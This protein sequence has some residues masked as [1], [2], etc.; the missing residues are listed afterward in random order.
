[1]GKNPRPINMTNIYWI[2]SSS[3]P[4]EDSLFKGYI[5]IGITF[6]LYHMHISDALSFLLA[7][8]FP[9]YFSWANARRNELACSH[10]TE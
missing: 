10:K 5:I 2:E 8:M 6:P 3:K 4:I 7:C 9:R 1:M